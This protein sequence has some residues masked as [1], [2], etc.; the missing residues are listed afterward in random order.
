MTGIV[1]AP[2]HSAVNIPINKNVNRIFF[3]VLIPDKEVMANS[4][5]EHPI[6]FP[7]SKNKIRPKT[8]A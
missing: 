6:F 7:Y 1:P 2:R 4:F 5:Q 3:T 8:R